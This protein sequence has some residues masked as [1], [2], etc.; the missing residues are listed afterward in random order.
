[1]PKSVDFGVNWNSLI[2]HESVRIAQD[3]WGTSRPYLQ[4]KSTRQRNAPV[5]ISVETITPIPPEIIN[6]HRN[7]IIGM[8]IM[9][10]HETPFLTTISRVI[11]FGS[12]TKMSGATMDT[13]VAAL[14]AIISKYE[15]RGSKLISAT[16]DN[17]FKALET[18]PDF[19]ELN[20]TLN[21]TADNEH[22]PYV[23][24]FNRIIKEK[25]PYGYYRHTTH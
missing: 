1:M 25:M 17:G 10:I 18:N 19:P 16:A 12:A 2:T 13:V 8:D 22:K 20:I 14:K 21:L 15:A 9:F 11:K 4:G 7:V 24:R 6:V 3:V 23:E 5:D